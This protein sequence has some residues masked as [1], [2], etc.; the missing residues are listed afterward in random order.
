MEFLEKRK[1]KRIK[2]P[3]VTRVRPSK[4]INGAD[5][6]TS[7]DI[8]TMKDISPSGMC[9]NYTKKIPVGTELEFKITLP[10]HEQP[11]KCAGKV[12]RIDEDVGQGGKISSAKILVYRI[13]VCF[14]DMD[15]VSKLAIS[16]LYDSYAR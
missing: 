8:V 12:C 11:I 4:N 5:I 13:A 2:H 10:L 14:K 15:A 9:F 16:S 6:S 1:D 7:W 3:F